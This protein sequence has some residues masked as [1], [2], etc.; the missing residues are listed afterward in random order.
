MVSSDAA[1]SLGSGRPARVWWP[2]RAFRR[3]AWTRP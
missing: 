2:F 1:D 3:W